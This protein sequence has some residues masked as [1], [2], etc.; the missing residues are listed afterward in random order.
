L[1]GETPQ[2]LPD[3]SINGISGIWYPATISQT[4]TYV[5]MPFEDQCAES[6]SVEI[7]VIKYPKFFTPN[8]DSYN[9]YWNI[10]DFTQEHQAEILI[11][12]R[13]GKLLKQLFP[14][15]QGWD[16]TYNGNNMP[17]NDYWFKVLYQ[18]P[19]LNGSYITK[20]FR[21]HFTLKR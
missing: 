15:G 12:D 2:P 11:F 19:E 17:T 7:K 3:V 9:D 4:D 5:F 16:G 14:P 21:A 18:V 8:Q 1:L 20:E 10:W 6:V 13:Y